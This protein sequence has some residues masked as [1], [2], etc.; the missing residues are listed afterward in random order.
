MIRF[1]P[2]PLIAAWQP[3][4]DTIRSFDGSYQAGQLHGSARLVR[5]L[6]HAGQAPEGQFY[7][8][9]RDDG[10]YWFEEAAMQKLKAD[11]LTDLRAQGKANPSALAAYLRLQLRDVLAIRR[12]WTPSFDYYALLQ[13]PAKAS[14]IALIGKIKKQGVYSRNVPGSSSA[15]RQGIFLPGGLTQYVINFGH[16]ANTPAKDWIQSPIRF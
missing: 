4:A 14:L 9:N 1:S 13:I 10:S 15:G 11:A 8:S 5:L 7:T 6:S 12:D 3:D 2:L 16:P